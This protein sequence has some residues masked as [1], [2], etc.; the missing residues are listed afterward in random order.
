MTSTCDQKLVERANAGEA[1]AFATLLE[2]H[3]D[4]MF[5]LAY[6][7]LG[8][9]QD[10]EDITQDICVSLPQKLKTFSG[11]SKLSTWLYQITVN[12]CRDF[13][14]QCVTS[15]KAYAD[16]S[17]VDRL[18]SEAQSQKRQDAIEAYRLIDTLHDDLRETALLVIAEG[19]SHA[20]AAQVLKIKESTVSW[21]MMKARENL[22]AQVQREAGVA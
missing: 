21:R 6:R 22:S 3:Y 14:R 13:R 7:M 19:L 12:R 11:R 17:D 1:P 16:F 8:N 18:R 20:E 9:R 10:A 15:R 5:R 2:R 4:L